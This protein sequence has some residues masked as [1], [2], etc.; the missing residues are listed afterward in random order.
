M[1]KRRKQNKRSLKRKNTRKNTRS[2]RQNRMKRRLM[3]AGA[4]GAPVT[5]I[6]PENTTQFPQIVTLNLEETHLLKDINSYKIDFDNLNGD[7]TIDQTR[8]GGSAATYYKDTE[9]AKYMIKLRHFA[10]P[11]D[12]EREV[13][14]QK[15]VKERLQKVPNI[16]IP[17]KERLQ[18]VPNIK[19]PEIIYSDT[20]KGL[21]VMEYLNP[22]S[23]W[24]PVALDFTKK[25]KRENKN[26]KRENEKT[27][28][29]F[30][31]IKAT[32]N[33]HGIKTPPDD[34]EGHGEVGAH[35]FERVNEKG[36][37]E[38]GIIDFGGAYEVN[39]E[40]PNSSS[41]AKRKTVRRYK[42]RRTSRHNDAAANQN[43]N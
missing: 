13:I 2:K 29:K 42:P 24:K 1:D 22:S 6:L 28:E 35:I 17:V 30:A 39:H 20:K 18:E 40:Y 31:I 19:I 8:I 37:T 12:Q 32:L 41:T 25:R 36:I 7:Y 5:I 26:G 3:I 34:F 23:G 11:V 14:K 10:Y 9:D 16:K 27:Q 38:T 15:A 21:I 33:L 43:N 4:A